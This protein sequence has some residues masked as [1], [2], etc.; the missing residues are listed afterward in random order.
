MIELTNEEQSNIS[1]CL[2]ILKSNEIVKDRKDGMNVYYSLNVCCIGEFFI[3]LNK[4][5]EENLESQITNLC[6]CRM[7]IQGKD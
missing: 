7:L 4:M 1:K 3:C 5:L 2:A 6:E